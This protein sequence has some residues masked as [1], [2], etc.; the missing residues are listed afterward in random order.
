M[1][2]DSSE[3]KA[4]INLVEEHDAAGKV[5]IVYDEIKDSLNIDF[6]P[7]MYKAM[8]VNPEYLEVS[9]NKIKSVMQNEGHLG[10]KTK[11][12]VALTVS[13]MSG[14]KY[15]IGVYNETVKSEGLDDA[16]LLELYEVIDLYTGL[17][18]FNIGLQTKADEKPWHGCGGARAS[19]GA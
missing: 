2:S 14:C 9:W 12:I 15:C 19:K 1:S 18:R 13:I 7:N 17:N 3:P 8:A 6:I 5:K 4:S 11:D 10:G 16:A